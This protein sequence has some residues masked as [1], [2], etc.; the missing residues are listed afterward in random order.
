MLNWLFNRKYNLV[1]TLCMMYMVIE[2]IAKDY[3]AV[4]AI[5]VIGTI[6]SMAGETA[7]AKQ[8]AKQ[9]ETGAEAESNK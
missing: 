8:E 4:V 9:E 7:L 1:D 6:V 3:F 5:L 2:F